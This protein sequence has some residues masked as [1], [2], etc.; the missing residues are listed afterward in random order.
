MNLDDWDYLGYS[1][2]TYTNKEGNAEARAFI[3]FFE[4]KEKDERHYEL[5]PQS[6]FYTFLTHS[7]VL[8]VVELWRIYEKETYEAVMFPSSA[9]KVDMTE[10]GYEWNEKDSKWKKI[11]KYET[12]HDS[13]VISLTK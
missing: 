13:N 6:S 2:A 1:E 4:H 11:L 10:I 9:L 7:F 12:S 5:V 8:T 3:Y